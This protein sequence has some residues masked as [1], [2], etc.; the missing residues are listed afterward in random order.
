MCTL[1]R[2]GALGAPSPAAA[3]T[4]DEEAVTSLFR[5]ATPSV[6]NITNLAETQDVFTRK[7]VTVPQGAG[8]GFLWNVEGGKGQVVTNFHVIRGA[9]DVQVT[10]EGG[11][12]LEGHVL[13]F[14]EDRDVAVI[15]VDV[16]RPSKAGSPQLR[17]PSGFPQR[18]DPT[19]GAVRPGPSSDG[20]AGDP[21]LPLATLPQPLER[22]RSEELMVG[23]RVFAIGNPF[24]LDHTITT[25]IVSGTGR[26]IASGNTGR[27]IEGVIQTDAAINPGNSGGPLLDS[28]GK[29]VGI[30][31][32]IYSA[33][34]T[35]SGV[36]FAVP[37]DAV[38]GEVQE[39]LDKGRVSKPVMGIA[40]APD[41][42]A[43]ELGIK[44]VLVLSTLENG[45]A[46]QA[47]IQATS[48]DPRGRVVLGDTVVSLDGRG[49]ESSSDL[50]SML[51]A[52]KVGD[53]VSVG[54]L[55]GEDI[56]TFSLD[57]IDANKPRPVTLRLKGTD[58]DLGEMPLPGF[59][60]PAPPGE[61]GQG[62]GL[63]PFGGGGGGPE[64]DGPG[65]GGAPG[66][67][68]GPARPGPGPPGLR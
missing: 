36:S 50:F 28:D 23:Q 15:E 57:L 19:N 12:A 43:E 56:E 17:G 27:P 46:A 68:G 38:G 49:I 10:F 21:S 63:T 48:R 54:V 37:I 62:P 42:L 33:S 44:G 29:V 45:P 4:R 25:G 26:Q 6:V 31:T 22:G 20:A 47:G 51:N 24:G 9:K 39:I 13:G 14:D 3:L 59:G 53:T 60:F 66:G 34:G 35:N 1:M 58:I 8:T 55:R 52:R 65:F 16:T 67:G 7:P 64:D 11:Q 41:A 40:L 5:R 61:E 30:N 2:A 18:L 32:A